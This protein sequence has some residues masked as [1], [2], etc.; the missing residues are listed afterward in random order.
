[1][2]YGK[3]LLKT[4][5][6]VLLMTCNIVSIMTGNALKQSITMASNTVLQ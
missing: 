3:E 5:N 4:C 6:T 1:M 2:T